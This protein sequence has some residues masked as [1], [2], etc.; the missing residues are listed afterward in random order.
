MS[1]RSSSSIAV[2]FAV[3][4]ITLLSARTLADA[5]P[6]DAGASVRP[7]IVLFLVDDLG[8]Q[9]VS[10]PMLGDASAL[11][12]RYHTPNL[13]KLA[14]RGLHFSNAYA[15]APVC[16][17]SRTAI[18]SGQ[19]P[20]RTHITYW[21]LDKDV[22]TS[23]PHPR[24]VQPKW[25]VHG[26][27]P[28]P[29]LLPALLRSAGYA[30]IHAGKSHLGARATEGADPLKMGYEINIAGHAAG[31][32][33]SYLGTQWFRD[34]ARKRAEK[35]DPAVP[36]DPAT[37]PASVW[38][39]PGLEK[40]HGQDIWLDDAIARDA[41]DAMSKAV[42]SA[43][44]FFLSFCPYGVHAPLMEDVRFAKDYARRARTE[45]RHDDRRRRRRAR[46][47]RRALRCA[48]SARPNRH[49]FYQRQRRAFRPLARRGARRYDRA[50]PQRAVALG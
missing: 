3:P 26:L 16:T 28:S 30:T 50:Q 31:A 7:N 11:N 1:S 12:A 40:W 32:P 17:P 29:Q 43:R 24:L 20:A 38:D 5:P 42:A 36:V 41:C 34:A 48:G 13:E 21:T 15:A 22:D 23:T 33:G 49:H 37:A 9:D 4:F 10:V 14:A 19:S 2:L 44:P 35:A 6:V 47:N 45:V 27:Q 18:I 25:E 8:Q 46:P 39:V